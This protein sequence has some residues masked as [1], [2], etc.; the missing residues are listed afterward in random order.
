MMLARPP[1][2]NFKMTIR[3]NDAASACSPLPSAYK[4]SC[5]LIVWG[6]SWGVE[7]VSLWTG[8]CALWL[9]EYKMKQSN[10]ASDIFWAVRS[11]TSF[12]VIGT[13][14]WASPEWSYPLRDTSLLWRDGKVSINYVYTQCSEHYDGSRSISRTQSSRDLHLCVWWAAWDAPRSRTWPQ[15]LCILWICCTGHHVAGWKSGSVYFVHKSSKDHL[16]FPPMFL[17]INQTSKSEFETNQEN[18]LGT[19][20]L[21]WSETVA[22]SPPQFW[23]LH[24]TSSSQSSMVD[25]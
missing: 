10:L 14:W 24:Q 1:M 9:P 5:P 21:E 19:I 17:G 7:A 6:G 18:C 8:V 4:S 12:F 25:L 13:Q 16:H 22:L 20:S 15:V 2:T 23:G 11:Q 3:A